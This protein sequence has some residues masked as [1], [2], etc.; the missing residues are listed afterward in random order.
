M[1]KSEELEL[2][3]KIEN[4]IRE[5]GPESYISGTFAGVVELAADN[6]KNDF[7]CNYKE[8][9]EAEQKKVAEIETFYKG[10]KDQLTEEIN[11][12]ETKL[13][14]ATK[15]IQNT[16]K[17]RDTFQSQFDKTYQCWAEAKTEIDKLNKDLETS[18][19]EIIVLKAKIYDLMFK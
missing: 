10:I 6:I 7:M 4:I 8:S 5:A 15:K 19:Q 11:Q 14:T 18:N 3:K 17:D 12:L 1:T 9:Y 13:E 16:E 2:L